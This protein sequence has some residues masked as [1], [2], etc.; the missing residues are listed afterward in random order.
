VITEIDA[1]RSYVLNLDHA[2]PCHVETQDARHL[3]QRL[4]AAGSAA[5]LSVSEISALKANVAG[6]MRKSKA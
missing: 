6:W 5:G 3:D 4:I 1:L 2:V